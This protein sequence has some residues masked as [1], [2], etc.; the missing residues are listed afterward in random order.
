MEI[1]HQYYYHKSHVV[2]KAV[3]NAI[4]AVLLIMLGIYAFIY[5]ALDRKRSKQ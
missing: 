1:L 3:G 5:I 4:L 2:I